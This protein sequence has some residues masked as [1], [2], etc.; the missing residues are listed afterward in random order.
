MSAEAPRTETFR[1][2]PG[3]RPNAAEAERRHLAVLRCAADMFLDQGFGEASIEEIARRAGVAKRFIYAR[4]KGKEELFVAA[5]EHLFA[6][7]LESLHEFETPLDDPEQGL[8]AYAS[9]MLELALQPDAVAVNRL[10]LTAAPRFPHL[11]RNFVERN[12]RRNLAGLRGLLQAYVERGAISSGDPQTLAE[13]FFMLTTG[14]PQRLALL[15]MREEPE[16]AQRRLRQAVR[17]FLD[18][19]RSRGK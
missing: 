2:G 17:L 12:R 15:G 14:I 11:A 7:K 6:D 9:H 3:G 10:L 1:R 16:E 18:G 19:S 4:Y 13:Y 8:L 5:I